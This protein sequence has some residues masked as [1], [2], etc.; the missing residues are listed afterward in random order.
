MCT[1][2]WFVRILQT[3]HAAVLGSLGRFAVHYYSGVTIYRIIEP[4]EL[5]GIGTFDN[6]VLYSLVYNGSYMLPNMVLALLL[7]ALLYK[8]MKPYF[9]GN[10]I[11]R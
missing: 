10:D 7:A 8:P 3:G 1:L 6:A 4:T 5:P 2:P 11:L 9:A